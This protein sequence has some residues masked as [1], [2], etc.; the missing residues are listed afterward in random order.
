M[1]DSAEKSK[2]NLGPVGGLVLGVIGFVVVYFLLRA[3]LVVGLL[4]GAGA[5]A[6]GLLMFGGRSSSKSM[7]VELPQ[8]VTQ[9][10]LDQALTEGRHK[11][12]LLKGY[13]YKISDIKVRKEADDICDITEK[14][15]K[16]IRQD[17]KDL[18]P[19]RQFLNY[20][21]DA[22]VKIL[23]RYVDISSRG[24]SGG[25]IDATL[26]RVEDSLSTIHKAFQKQLAKLME[27]DVMDLDTELEVLDRTI[28]MEGLGDDETK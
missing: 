23:R 6:A 17:P 4:A 1:S 14:I 8:G 11:L 25:E 3:E 19:A 7:T 13:A 20:Y 22:T 26:K 9:E 15:L 16:D 18:R 24:L 27:D 21:L 2:P 28:R 10:A 12:N 5:F